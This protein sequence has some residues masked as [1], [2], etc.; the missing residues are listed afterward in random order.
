MDANTDFRIDVTLVFFLFFLEAVLLWE[1]ASY[2][3]ADVQLS[4]GVHQFEDAST[5]KEVDSP[6]LFQYKVLELEWFTC[7]ENFGKKNE[8]LKKMMISDNHQIV[9]HESDENSSFCH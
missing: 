6:P 4:H 7:I 9:L 8:K 2:S 5:Q 1:L 3:Y